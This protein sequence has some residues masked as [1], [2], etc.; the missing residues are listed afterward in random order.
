MITELV[1]F[2][3]DGLTLRGVLHLP[4]QLPAPV[5]VGCHGL[6]ADKESPKQQALALACCDKGLAFFR[7]D[8]RGCGQSDGNFAAVTSLAARCRDLERAVE[9]VSGQSKILG[10]AALFGSSMG[11][12][13][14]LASA[15]QWPGI[16]MVT[17]AAP[18][19][20]EPVAAAVQLSDN[21]T[22]R[23]LPPSF[24]DQALRFDISPAVMGLSNILL[25][26]GE[27]DAVVP[28]EHAR[29]IYDLCAD[30]RELVIFP[31]GDHRVSDLRH[32]KVFLTK[33]VDWLTETV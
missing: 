31:G 23:T 19:E 32:Q 6:F 17:V 30:P 1:S 13:V 3:S 22:A 7:F 8:H 28:V 5:A 20:S 12:A 14:V 4:D 21:S 25:F 24:Y 18:L 26:H 9:T 11:G 2:V 10:L 29:R 33:A 16:R 27:K 15:R